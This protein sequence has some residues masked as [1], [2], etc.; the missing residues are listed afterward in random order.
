MKDSLVKLKTIADIQLEN[1]IFYIDAFQRGYRWDDNQVRDLLEDIYEFSLIKN[2]PES[3]FYCLQPVILSK[4]EDAQDTWSVIDGQQRLTTLFLIYIHYVAMSGKKKVLLPFTLKYSNKEKLESCLTD[5]QNSGFTEEDELGD[6]FN[7]YSD[8]IDCYYVLSAYKEICR[9]FHMLSENPRTQNDD[10]I[11]KEVFDNHMKIIWYELVNASSK[12]EVTI[13]SN[14]NMGKIPLTNAELI[15]ALLLKNDMSIDSKDLSTIQDNIAIKW[16]EIEAQLRDPNFWAFLANENEEAYPTRIDYIFRI[17]AHELNNTVLKK[18]DSNYPEDEPYSVSEYSNKDKFSFYVFNNYVRLLLKHPSND[19]RIT[20]NYVQIIWNR[21]CEYYRMFSDWYQNPHWYHLIGYI[22][23]ISNTRYI[24]TVCMLSDLYRQ[25]EDS[26]EGHKTYFERKLREII[27]EKVFGSKSI[28]PAEVNSFIESL[29]YGK[30]SNEIR[31]ILLLYNISYL[32]LCGLGGR[33]PFEKY[34]NKDIAWDIEHINA[35]ADDIPGD[36][37][38]DKEDN[39][40]LIWLNETDFIPDDLLT[41]DGRNVKDLISKIKSEKLYLDKYQVGTPDFILVYEAV[42]GYFGDSDSADNSIA[43]LTLLDSVTNRSYK[44]AVF[45]VKRRTIIENS[46]KDFFIPLC[47]RN[48]FLKAYVD[49]SNLLK[50]SGDD[51]KTYVIDIEANIAK[52]LELLENE[53]E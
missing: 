31:N 37:K 3:L 17:M 16:D 12:Q 27:C 18:A 42:I 7:T 26:T 2:K 46:M 47:T 5:I 23:E 29:T 11:M 15:K 34:K 28:S 33:F 22:V 20:G 48:V 45:P 49:S 24:D 35:I 1:D 32:E 30:N 41:S 51:K 4:L 40:R 25:H 44:N 10:S 9:F 14:I 19:N 6:L 36:S 50:W 43:N 39:Q 52:Y 21:V 8:D 13:F 38:N 53:H